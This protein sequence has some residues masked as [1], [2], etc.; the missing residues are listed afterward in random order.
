MRAWFSFNLKPCDNA[1][2]QHI[3]HWIQTTYFMQDGEVCQQ[4]LGILLIYT[5]AVNV[6]QVD[7]SLVLP[8]YHGHG[9]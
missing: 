2:Y 8:L 7:I 9:E 4:N 3:K 1:S 5:S 6:G